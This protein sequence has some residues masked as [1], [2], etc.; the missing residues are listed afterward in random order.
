MITSVKTIYC[1]YG[2]LACEKALWETGSLCRGG[3]YKGLL[4]PRRPSLPVPQKAFS[5]P[6]SLLAPLFSLLSRHPFL[7]LRMSQLLFLIHLIFSH[8][9]KI[10]IPMFK[11]EFILHTVYKKLNIHKTVY[12]NKNYL[13]KGYSD[14]N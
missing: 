8:S 14:R 6:N 13:K 11:L 7:T 12:S 4:L 1:F 2:L 3:R 9:S 5:Q 10:E